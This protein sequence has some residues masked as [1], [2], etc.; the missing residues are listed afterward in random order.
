MHQALRYIGSLLPK[1]QMPSAEV[2]SFSRRVLCLIPA[3]N[4][5][6]R[7]LQVQ[8]SHTAKHSKPL[9][10]RESHALAA[11]RKSPPKKLLGFLA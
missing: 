7:S 3:F 6:D 10:G 5:D 1:M 2:R 8:V 11:R 4:R 9:E